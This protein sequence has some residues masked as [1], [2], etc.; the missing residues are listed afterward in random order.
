MDT[1]SAGPVELVLT[2][3]PCYER[4]GL[5]HFVRRL[6]SQLDLIHRN[7]RDYDLPPRPAI[8]GGVRPES[9]ETSGQ[10]RLPD[11]RH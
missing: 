9:S 7:R 3:L 10:R 1:E 6:T 2:D 11:V 4:T 8:V 5:P